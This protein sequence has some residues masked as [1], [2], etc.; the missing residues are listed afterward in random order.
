M[1][2][3]CVSLLVGTV[4]LTLMAVPTV[5]TGIEEVFA[6]GREDKIL[7]FDTMVG[8]PRPFTG[9]M[10]AIRGVAGGG[11]PWVID[12]GVGE[13]RTNGDI[14]VKVEGLVIDPNDPDAIE[15]G[16]AGMNPAP[17]F[18]AIV[19]CLTKDETGNAVIM[20]VETGL[21]PADQGGD[22]EIRHNVDLPDPCIA[23]IVFVTSPGGAWF[24]ATGF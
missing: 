20:N 15:R 4:M 12:K 21:F 10:N 2:K 23:P 6:G 19:S 17:F 8:V 16:L 13:L 1:K 11:L 18:K 22:S 7:K 9:M 3:K 24:A 14:K 5:Q